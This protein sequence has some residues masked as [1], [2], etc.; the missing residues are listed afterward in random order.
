MKHLISIMVLVTSTSSY[1]LFH[2]FGKLKEKH[3]QIK[4]QVDE[5]F[6]QE[7]M[8]KPQPIILNL[9]NPDTHSERLISRCI[10]YYL[11]KKSADWK[12]EVIHDQNGCVDIKKEVCI[13]S[14]HDRQ[15]NSLY[16]YTWELQP[17]KCGMA[18]IRA[19]FTAPYR[20]DNPYIQE[21]LVTVE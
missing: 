16:L 11:F 2:C 20:K 14:P 5:T 18:L 9:R 13:S 1:P 21:F 15:K 3:Y 8:N 6:L 10:P 7:G 4:E 19:T 12:F 17:K